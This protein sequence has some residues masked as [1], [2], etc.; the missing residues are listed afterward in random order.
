M[1]GGGHR[2]AV[3]V[4]QSGVFSK[5]TSFE[6]T[7]LD[8]QNLHSTRSR[9]FPICGVTAGVTAT[10]YTIPHLDTLAHLFVR[11]RRVFASQSSRGHGM[12]GKALKSPVVDQV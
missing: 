6:D 11:T 4:L 3:Y 10:G 1:G 2:R 7:T 5:L 12:T 8:F 9:N